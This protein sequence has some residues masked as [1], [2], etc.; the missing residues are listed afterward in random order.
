[1]SIANILRKNLDFSMVFPDLQHII[2]YLGFGRVK[3]KLL[4]Y[5]AKYT[6]LIRVP[7]LPIYQAL[8]FYLWPNKSE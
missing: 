2:I 5:I 8:A 4:Y 1:M 6:V 3:L 7:I